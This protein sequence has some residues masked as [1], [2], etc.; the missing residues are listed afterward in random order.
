MGG[1]MFGY[2]RPLKDDLK[3]REYEQFKT[4]YC[5]LCHT[6]K[7]AYGP[8]PRFFLS[9]D[10]TFL[11][12]LLW[13]EG[14]LPETRCGRCAASPINKKKYCLPTK[15]LKI[16]AGYSVIL[17]WWKLQDAI[18]DEG[19]FGKIRAGIFSVLTKRAYNKAAAKTPDFAAA[20]ADR[21][22]RL[23]ELE[24]DNITSLDETAEQFAS[25]TASMADHV[26]ED[27]GRRA[28]K[29]LLYH[30]GRFIY[31]LDAINDLEEDYRA[32]R[33]NPVAA[34]FN[35]SGGILGDEEKR[36]L[37][38]TLRHSVNMIGTAYELLP[39][40]VWTPITR[41]IIYLGMPEAAKRVLEGTWR[42]SPILN[43]NKGNT[44]H[45]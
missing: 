41:N 8:L 9:Y 18:M 40:N 23:G 32:G 35:I 36:A 16:S 1:H 43:K 29:Q 17:S 34:R 31:I 30:T 7:S 14:E 22:K 2:I 33:Y 20:V 42:K 25:I 11:S 13:D 19:C 39:K 24:K 28:L 12:M 37:D 4:C 3:V 15:A 45:E 44:S 38:L 26:E 5:A 6:L 21:L 27:A 10:F